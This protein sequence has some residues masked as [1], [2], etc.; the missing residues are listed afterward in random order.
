MFILRLFFISLR[1]NRIETKVYQCF[2][3]FF[4]SFLS[5]SFLFQ[6]F[7]SNY[8]ISLNEVE[9]PRQV[10]FLVVV[11]YALIHDWFKNSRAMSSS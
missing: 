2:V 6:N 9:G 3:L 4:F 1:A 10:F 8:V 11:C 5:L 7:S